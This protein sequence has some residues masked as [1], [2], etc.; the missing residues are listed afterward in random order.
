M[1]LTSSKGEARHWKTTAMMRIEHH[2]LYMRVTCFSVPATTAFSV[3]FDVHFVALVA[4]SETC[5]SMA[6]SR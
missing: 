5:G 6:P 2:I 1:L 4:P 3:S